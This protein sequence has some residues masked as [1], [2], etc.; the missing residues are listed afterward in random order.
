MQAPSQLH[1]CNFIQNYAGQKWGLTKQTSQP[2]QSNM[3]SHRFMSRMLCTCMKLKVELTICNMF[4]GHFQTEYKV[5]ILD[6]DPS[7]YNMLASQYI[8]L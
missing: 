4:L 1:T 8:S 5:I 3:G 7:V 2:T 6:R